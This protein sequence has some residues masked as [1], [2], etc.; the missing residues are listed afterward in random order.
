[1]PRTCHASASSNVCA[2]H[3]A[4]PGSACTR[5]RMPFSARPSSRPGSVYEAQQVARRSAHTARVRQA[6]V[7]GALYPEH[8]FHRA[9]LSRRGRARASCRARVLRAAVPCRAPFARPQRAGVG[10][11]CRFGSVG[12]ICWVSLVDAM[13][14]LSIQARHVDSIWINAHLATL[15]DGKYGVIR[16]A[17]SRG[18][19]QDRLV[20]ARA[21][22][23]ASRRACA[24]GAR[25]RRP[26]DHAR[27][28]RLH[29]HLVHAAIARA[30]SSCACRA[31]AP[32][33]SPLGGGIAATVQE[34]RDASKW[35]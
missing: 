34:T 24:R 17:R 35:N 15:R 25:L 7:E 16:R 30:S 23:P 11:G 22:L 4:A 18:S 3:A 2:S 20:G 32:L 27:A 8:E 5:L 19:G 13:I 33:R 26:L 14:A 29:T 28:D 1:M 10:A 21:D 6:H 12:F 9:R 31:Q